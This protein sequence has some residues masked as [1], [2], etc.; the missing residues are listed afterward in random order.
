MEFNYIKDLKEVIEYLDKYEKFKD[1]IPLKIKNSTIKILE[2]NL[3][4]SMLRSDLESKEWFDLFE[5]DSDFS[6]R[7]V[8]V[9][10]GSC[11]DSMKKMGIAVEVDREDNT[12]RPYY[13]LKQHYKELTG[14]K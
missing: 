3:I 4:L 10:M 9:F 12:N 5:E 6:V 1:K 8:D 11:F 14:E 13:M 7:L 2:A